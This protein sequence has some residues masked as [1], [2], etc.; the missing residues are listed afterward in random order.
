[1]CVGQE[2]ECQ[3]ARVEPGQRE[4]RRDEDRKSRLHHLLPL[5]LRV[6]AVCGRRLNGSVRKS[7]T[8]SRASSS[9]HPESKGLEIKGSKFRL[10]IPR[11]KFQM[12]STFT[13]IHFGHVAAKRSLPCRR[14][15]RPFSPRRSRVSTRGYTRSTILGDRSVVV[16]VAP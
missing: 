9:K 10:G 11:D 3:V 2:D 15:C 1:M 16:F 5:C 4:K 6:D 7:V 12:F 13:S 14:C 8:H